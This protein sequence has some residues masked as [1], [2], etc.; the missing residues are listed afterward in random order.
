MHVTRT[1]LC[2][3]HQARHIAACPWPSL[4]DTRKVVPAHTAFADL[5]RPRRNAGQWMD[6]IP[7][8]KKKHGRISEPEDAR[9]Q[10]N[11]PYQA[12]LE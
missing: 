8:K 5:R 11:N 1:S 2:V 9:R 4:L 12:R 10:G 3:F 6:V 7:R